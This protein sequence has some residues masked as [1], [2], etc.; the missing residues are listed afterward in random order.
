MAFIVLKALKWALK[1]QKLASDTL[2]ILLANTY[3]WNPCWKVDEMSHFWMIVYYIDKS[4][5][6][7]LTYNLPWLQQHFDIF[8]L[9]VIWLCRLQFVVVCLIFVAIFNQS[10]S[11]WTKLRNRATSHSLPNRPMIK[12]AQSGNVTTKTTRGRFRR[13]RSQNHPCDVNKMMT[14]SQ[15]KK[16]LKSVNCIFANNLSKQPKMWHC[17]STFQQGF[18]W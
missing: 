9:T 14:R 13:K 10:Q 1:G 8:D 11:S 17:S 16:Y 2:K 15:K 7:L 5:T 12:H 3:H 4:I 18:Q 6:F